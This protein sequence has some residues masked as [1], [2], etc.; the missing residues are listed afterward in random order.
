MR[1]ADPQGTGC[2][3]ILTVNPYR[4]SSPAYEIKMLILILEFVDYEKPDIPHPVPATYGEAMRYLFPYWRGGSAWLAESLEHA[5]TSFC[6]RIVHF[7][8]IWMIV[9]RTTTMGGS[10]YAEAIITQIPWTVAVY[11]TDAICPDDK[12]PPIEELGTM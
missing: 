3:G 7:R 4:S 9:Q 10:Q 8:D 2:T 5:R 1:Y 6:P 12:L 11:R